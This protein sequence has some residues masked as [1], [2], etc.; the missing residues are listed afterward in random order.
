MST[1]VICMIPIAWTLAMLAIGW[2]I[3][4]H[5]SPIRW[6]GFRRSSGASTRV[7]TQYE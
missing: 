7:T 1:F 3:G 5:G 4:R 6:I 2:Y